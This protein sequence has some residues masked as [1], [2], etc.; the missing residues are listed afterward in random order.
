MA[1]LRSVSSQRTIK[2]V[3]YS[4]NSPS[5][6]GLAAVAAAAATN[7]NGKCNQKRSTLQTD[8]AT[9]GSGKALSSTSSSLNLTPTFDV[10]NGKRRQLHLWQSPFCTMAASELEHEHDALCT[11]LHTINSRLKLRSPRQ[12]TRAKVSKDSVNRSQFINRMRRGNRNGILSMSASM[13]QLR[14]S[15]ARQHGSWYAPIWFT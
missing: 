6:S 15:K 9:A 7:I 4:C 13:I 12:W 1:Q 11:R 10:L 2:L 3:Y 14:L 8:A 5:S